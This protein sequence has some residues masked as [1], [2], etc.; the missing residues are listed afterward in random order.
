MSGMRMTFRL[1][2]LKKPAKGLA[3]Y[4]KGISFIEMDR[5][6]IHLIEL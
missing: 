6:R 2:R 5:K 1:L 3:L 4:P